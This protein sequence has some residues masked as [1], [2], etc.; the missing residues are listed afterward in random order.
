MRQHLAKRAGG[1]FFRGFDNS[2]AG[3]TVIR[4]VSRRFDAA[5]Q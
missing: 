1:V 3:A 5:H 4:R 2:K